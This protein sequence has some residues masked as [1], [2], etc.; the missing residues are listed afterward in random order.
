MG[1][2]RFIHTPTLHF[3]WQVI[4]PDGLPDV[5]LTF[6]AN[7]WLRSLSPS[8]VPVYLRELIAFLRWAST[9]RVV[10][11]NGWTLHGAPTEVRNLVREY[12]CSG[13]QCKVTAR[14][15]RN[16]LRV[17]HVRTTDQ[18]HILGGTCVI[19]NL[20]PAKFA[21]VG[22]T[23]NAPDPTRQHEVEKKLAWAAQQLAWAEHEELLAEARQMKALIRDCNLM[24]EEMK[25]IEAAKANTSQLVKI[26]VELRSG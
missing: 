5:P 17:L 21:C 23:G 16:G 1:T 14:P 12:L 19:G 25:L 4:R 24:L 20:C 7:E 2:Y 9:D 11:A 18:T 8:T 22:C 3:R 13:A 26:T 10:Q 6:A 15:D